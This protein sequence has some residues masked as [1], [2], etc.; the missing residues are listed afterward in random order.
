MLPEVEV[1]DVVD[2]SFGHISVVECVP[3]IGV[4][5][6]ISSVSYVVPGF[7]GRPYMHSKCL[8]S[9]LAAR[10]SGRDVINI[11]L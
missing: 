3:Q 2:L 4:L 7:G 11:D 5:L 6:N 1:L 10:S 8:E 9:V